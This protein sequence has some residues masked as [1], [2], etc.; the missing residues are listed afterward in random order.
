MSLIQRAMSCYG[1]ILAGY[2]T[3]QDAINGVVTVGGLEVDRNLQGKII[4]A[5]IRSEIR[6]GVNLLTMYENILNHEHTARG[7]KVGAAEAQL[8]RALRE[9]FDRF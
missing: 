7:G 1:K 3:G 5:V 6:A 4:E 8:V 2:T 9:E